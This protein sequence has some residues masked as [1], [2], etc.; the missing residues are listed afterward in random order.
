M[1]N[2]LLPLF[3]LLFSGIFFGQSLFGGV[4]KDDK[5]LHMGGCYVL[6]SVTTSLIY[7]KTNDKKKAVTYGILTTMAIGS[8][9]EIHDIKHGDSTWGDMGAN[10]AGATLGV[11]TVK[12]NF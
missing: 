8:I 11:L 6:S 7:N 3:T 1:K 9:K 2:L 4:I 10:L 12:I 5:L